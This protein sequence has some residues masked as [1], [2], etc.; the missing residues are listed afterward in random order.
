[1]DKEL[2]EICRRAG[3]TETRIDEISRR[4]LKHKAQDELMHGM[5]AAFTWVSERGEFEEQELQA[6]L[7]EMERQFR[8]I[9][10]FLQYEPGS[11]SPGA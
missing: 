1:M 10:R 2:E 4:E 7:Q 11:W 5:Q 3:L 8:R 9:E 6:I